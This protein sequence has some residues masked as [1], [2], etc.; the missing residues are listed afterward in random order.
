MRSAK[1]LLAQYQF[2]LPP[3]AV[4][5]PD[6][7][8]AKGAEVRE[9]VENQLG[10]DI[11]DFASGDFLRRG[12]FLFTVRNGHPANLHDMQ[13]KRCRWSTM[14]APTTVFMNPSGAFLKSSR[15]SRR[16]TC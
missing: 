16:C 3:F 8:R 11:T 7:W 5:T 6:E 14:T 12:L 2:H 10:W 1:E 9:I 15:T 13:G 4:W